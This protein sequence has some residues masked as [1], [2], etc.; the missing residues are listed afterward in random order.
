MTFKRKANRLSKMRYDEVS[1]VGIGA[2]Q[3]ALLVLSKS[4]PGPSDVHAAGCSCK[5][6][7]KGAKKMMKSGAGAAAIAR[8]EFAKMNSNHSK[9]NGE[10]TSGGG[11][12]GV[13]AGTSRGGGKMSSKEVDAAQK[14]GGVNS[15]GAPT[16]GTKAHAEYSKLS[17]TERGDYRSMRSARMTARTGKHMGHVWAMKEI[18]MNR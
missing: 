15:A 2:H 5:T 17:S 8:Y 11:G 12:G 10:F 6:C 1:L 18:V 3:D 14:K 16:T 4:D 9:A 13:R 7:S